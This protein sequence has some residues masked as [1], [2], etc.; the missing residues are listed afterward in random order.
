MYFPSTCNGWIRISVPEV[1]MVTLFISDENAGER[2]KIAASMT[3][4]KI[5]A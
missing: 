2:L 1:P 4:V 5:N 3:N